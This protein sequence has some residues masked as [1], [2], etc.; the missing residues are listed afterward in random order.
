MEISKGEDQPGSKK[1]FQMGG[2]K[3]KHLLMIVNSKWAAHEGHFLVKNQQLWVAEYDSTDHGNL[4]P[5]RGVITA[6]ADADVALV[7]LRC[8]EAWGSTFIF[9]LLPF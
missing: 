3:R 5:G 1:L 2:R 8:T 4:G 9:L 7:D 6:H